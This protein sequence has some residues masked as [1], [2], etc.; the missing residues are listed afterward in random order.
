MSKFGEKEIKT[1]D[2]GT[3]I[4]KDA[5]NANPKKPLDQPPVVATNNLDPTTKELT[6]HIHEHYL[7]VHT[8]FGHHK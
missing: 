8:P 5:P 1:G 6:H 4:D 2:S 7:A 3:E